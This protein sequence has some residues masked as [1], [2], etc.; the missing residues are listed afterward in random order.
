MG[1]LSPSAFQPL[2]QTR[3]MYSA[4]RAAPGVSFDPMGKAEQALWQHVL[5]SVLIDLC[6]QGG[7]HKDA[8]V[9]AERWI[10]GFASRDFRMVCSL[11]GFEPDAVWPVLRRLALM[12]PSE[13][14]RKNGILTQRFLT[15]LPVLT[16]GAV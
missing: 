8:R 11:A 13:R 2:A 5:L 15:G 10:G 14:R 7:R 3:C 12:E 4:V 6:A 1:D 16:Q 9:T